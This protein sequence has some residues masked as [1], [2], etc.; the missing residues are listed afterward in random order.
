MAGAG[1]TKK[2]PQHRIL[3]PLLRRIW[4]MLWT[5]SKL[6][7]LGCTTAPAPICQQSEANTSVRAVRASKH[8]CASP[9]LFVP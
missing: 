2:M 1:P 5:G 6:D 9:V 3:L 4:R 8:T 7:S